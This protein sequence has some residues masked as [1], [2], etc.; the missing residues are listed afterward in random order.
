MTNATRENVTVVVL[1]FGD[2]L[3]CLLKTLD[4]IEKNSPGHIILVGNA[5]SNR[6]RKEIERRAATCSGN[7]ST[8]FSTM[9]VGSAGGYALGIE[10]ALN[11][12]ECD[13]LWLLDDDNCPKA[14]TLDTI[15][16]CWNDNASDPNTAV[17]THRKTIQDYDDPL[18]GW[19]GGVP[20]DGSCIGFHVF[21]LVSSRITGHGD[22][23]KFL[24]WSVYGGL[25]TP[26]SL[27]RQIG[28]PKQEFFLYGDDLEWTRRIISIG[29]RIITCPDAEIVDLC[30]SWNMT[31]IKG[32]NLRRR[33]VDLEAFRVYYEVRNRT[34]IAR[35]YFPGNRIIY[36]LNRSLYLLVSLISATR[37]NRLK[38]FCL[39][40]RAILEGE[41]GQLGQRSENY[42]HGK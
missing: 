6:V 12:T 28:L 20:K 38:R 29:G 2:R 39:I 32:S 42:F 18:D 10:L 15:L 19:V 17:A 1:C 16:K 36:F 37:Y 33:I 34:W 24:P 13:L 31:G 35:N 11:F 21:N 5:V 7:Y 3:E 26:T 22:K 41:R 40:N 23:P 25:L 14:D 4:F 8:I 9:N 30:P 27:I